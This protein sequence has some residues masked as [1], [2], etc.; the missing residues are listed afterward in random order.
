MGVGMAEESPRR[1]LGRGLAA[2]IGDVDNE[3]SAI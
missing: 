2:L 3:A 1:G